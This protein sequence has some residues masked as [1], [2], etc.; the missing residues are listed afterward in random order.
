[1]ALSSPSLELHKLVQGLAPLPPYSQSQAFAINNSGQIAGVSFTPSLGAVAMAWSDG[2]PYIIG[3]SSSY[4]MNDYGQVVGYSG[5]H[6]FL[7]TPD[8]ANGKSGIMLDLGTLGGVASAGIA[9]NSSG[10]W[11]VIRMIQGAIHMHFCGRR[12]FPMRGA[13]AVWLTWARCPALP[14]A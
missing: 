14:G 2:S 6:G 1:M 9:V 13:L 3:G 11:S 7:W 10:K 12:N 4:G 8:L 5:N